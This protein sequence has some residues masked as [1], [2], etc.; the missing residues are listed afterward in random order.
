[1]PTKCP[2]RKNCSAI[3]CDPQ[4]IYAADGWSWS[5]K[6]KRQELGDS[7]MRYLLAWDTCNSTN[8]TPLAYLAFRFD[9]EDNIPAVYV[10]E[11]QLTDSLRRK[12]VGR[13]LMQITELLGCRYMMDNMDDYN[14]YD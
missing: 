3:L 5:R 7:A 14:K 13:F 1:M 2:Y 12:G 6:Q 10:Y 8:T 4:D 9:E 11:V